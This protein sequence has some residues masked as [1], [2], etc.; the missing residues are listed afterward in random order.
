MASNTRRLKLVSS[1]FGESPNK[2]EPCHDPKLRIRFFRNLALVATATSILYIPPIYDRIAKVSEK[3]VAS[4]N[5]EDSAPRVQDG[6]FCYV[7]G[8]VDGTPD[9]TT[10]E[11]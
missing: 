5:S 6:D 10:G 8:A 4:F 1:N 2:D 11:C 3:I 7:E 9:E